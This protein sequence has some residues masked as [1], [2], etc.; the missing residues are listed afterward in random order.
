MRERKER[1]HGPYEHFDQ[2]RVILVGASGKRRVVPFASE[3]EALTFA[4][5]ARGEA[6][7]RTVTAAVDLWIQSK[8]DRNLKKTSIT[9]A[10]Y[11]LRTP[12]AS[13]AFDGNMQSATNTG[14]GVLAINSVYSQTINLGTLGDGTW[15][16]GSTS[17]GVGQNGTYN[18]GSVGAGKSYNFGVGNARNNDAVVRLEAPG[19]VLGWI[20][21][22]PIVA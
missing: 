6:E 1:V 11:H 2:W 8:R 3:R 20:Q 12:Q 14:A 13:G 16:L 18:G 15:F 19:A 21:L 10:D 5:A 7:G 17:N 4:A 22:H 9:R